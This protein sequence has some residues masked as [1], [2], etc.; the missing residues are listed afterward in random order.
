[1]R[2]GVIDCSLG[3]PVVRKLLLSMVRPGAADIATNNALRYKARVT[4]GRDNWFAQDQGLVRFSLADG[5]WTNMPIALTDAGVSKFGDVTVPNDV[6]LQRIGSGNE[7]LAGR[8]IGVS[9][10]GRI[11]IQFYGWNQRRDWLRD[12][13]GGIQ[14]AELVI[15]MAIDTKPTADGQDLPWVSSCP[16]FRRPE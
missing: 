6:L 12:R 11:G 4:L 3:T 2:P 16:G 14:A 7:D 8:D 13:F 1:M 5:A 10:F 15:V 9:P